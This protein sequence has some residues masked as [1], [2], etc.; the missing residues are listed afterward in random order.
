MKSVCII[1]AG[2][3]AVN[4]AHALQNKGYN[5]V[6]VFSKTIES[7]SRLA[8]QLNT[9][10]TND[11]SDITGNADIYIFAIKDDSLADIIAALPTNNSLW[12][13]TAGSMP[14]EVFK[15]KANK[16]GVLYPLQTFNK[17]KAADW[18]N[19][20]ILIEGTDKQ[21]LNDIETLARTLTAKVYPV[22][23]E[24]RKYVH[25]SAVFACN[26][27][28]YMYTI[29]HD[30]MQKS[31]L[32]F[33]LLLPLIEETCNKIHTRSPLQVQTGP[34][35]RYDLN[36]INKHLDLIEDE[37]IKHIYLMLSNAIHERHKS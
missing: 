27:V 3:V 29:G 17:N 31:D 24:T 30:F 10:F 1:G 5:I 15:E 34:A 9:A 36:V 32:P 2:N 20:P 12:L 13:H 19:I 26:F 33:S 23:S 22:D 37:Q 6:Q 21:T 25:L 8:A 35:V 4:L 14:M 11:V 7:A 16:Y 28:N 18:D